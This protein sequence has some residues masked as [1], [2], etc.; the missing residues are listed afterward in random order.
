MGRIPG[1]AA[2]PLALQSR[3][4]INGVCI[5]ETGFGILNAFGKLHSH[6][7]K[8]STRMGRVVESVSPFS[9]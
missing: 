4:T 7:P 6:F 9:Q 2:D 3:G 8:A 1:S 5:Y